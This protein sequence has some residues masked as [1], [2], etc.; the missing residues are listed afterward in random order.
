MRR[1]RA[2]ATV[3]QSSK[4]RSRT[5]VR[6]RLIAASLYKYLRQVVDKHDLLKTERAEKDSGTSTT[7]NASVSARPM[8]PVMRR[9]E[10]RAWLSACEIWCRS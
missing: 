2:T 9:R 10:R 1:R 7:T 5:T 4:G 8:L 6:V 3:K